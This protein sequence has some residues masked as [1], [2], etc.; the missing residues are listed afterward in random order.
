M[1][2][3]A[4]Q[5]AAQ[6]RAEEAARER[7]AMEMAAERRERE[8]VR[9]FQQNNAIADPAMSIA[10]I[11]LEYKIDKLNYFTTGTGY[12]PSYKSIIE[13]IRGEEFKLRTVDSKTTEDVSGSPLISS[14]IKA[15][16]YIRDWLINHV[17]QFIPKTSASTEIPFLPKGCKYFRSDDK[18]IS[19][20][21]EVPP[22][23]FNVKYLRIVD[24]RFADSEYS[25]ED[26]DEEDLAVET[27]EIAIPWQYFWIQFA[28]V[29]P[30][31]YGVT[32]TL[33]NQSLY[34]AADRVMTLRDLVYPARLPNIYIGTGVICLGEAFPPSNLAPV[35]R[36]EHLV[37]DFYESVFNADLAIQ[38]PYDM[39]KWEEKSKADPFVWMNWKFPDTYPLGDYIRERKEKSSLVRPEDMF[40]YFDIFELVSD[41]IQLTQNPQREEPEVK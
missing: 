39:K 20:L 23:K 17:T 12:V 16:N 37:A 28:I 40:A 2:L 11:K 5:R 13:L 35:D 38:I 14:H 24:L 21:I 32:H 8:R 3:S 34:W 15:N 1:R 26:A 25:L 36:A 4:A 30:N 31:E 29:P 10:N 27:V 6:A 33:K 9:R 41:A 18:E 19:F 22:G 7:A